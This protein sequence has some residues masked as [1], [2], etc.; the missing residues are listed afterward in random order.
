MGRC[1]VSGIG[2]QQDLLHELLDVVCGGP[3]FSGLD[4]PLHVPVQLGQQVVPLGAQDKVG[5]GQQDKQRQDHPETESQTFSDGQ[6]FEHGVPLGPSSSE[7][8]PWVNYGQGIR[9]TAKTKRPANAGRQCGS[10]SWN[11]GKSSWT[12]R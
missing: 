12:S 1:P 10:S 3:Q 5:A 9:P 11:L 6:V 2:G 8:H 7:Y 4:G